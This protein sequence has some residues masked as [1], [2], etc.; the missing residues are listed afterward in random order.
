MNL[1][2][3]KDLKITGT[4]QAT[5]GVYDKVKITGQ[6]QIDGTLTCDS[7][8]ITGDGRVNGL[9][10]AGKISING[11]SVITG[12]VHAGSVSVNGQLDIGQ[13]TSAKEIRL[14][15]T[16]RV[17]G[18]LIG[19][20]IRARGGLDVEGDCE[21]EEF[22]A[23]G[24]FTIDG[25]LN[26]GKL[27]LRMHWP[28]RVKEIGGEQ[29]K[30]KRVWFHGNIFGALVRMFHSPGAAR[31]AADCIEGDYIELEHTDAKVIRGNHIIIG[32]GC[33]VE[34]VEYRRSLHIADDAI[35]R[36]HKKV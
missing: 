36:T 9:V 5:G 33:E 16:M 31:L 27:D 30:V 4:G 28:C 35:V 8:V 25:L 10:Q 32:P 1:E 26:V 34:Q 22:S 7:M 12:N 11:S 17:G 24:A 19:E 23:K 14:N 2:R 18:H 13:G 3:N 6:G 20:V 29:I 15:G 21:I